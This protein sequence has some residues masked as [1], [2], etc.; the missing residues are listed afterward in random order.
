MKHK[1]RSSGTEPG[2]KPAKVVE[3]RSTQQNYIAAMSERAK[4]FLGSVKWTCLVLRRPEVPSRL[5]DNYPCGTGMRA[6]GL[7]Q[8]LLLSAPADVGGH[9][10]VS[11]HLRVGEA[12][13]WRA[14]PGAPTTSVFGASAAATPATVCVQGLP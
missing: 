11:G 13:T 3:M 6:G 8:R 4:K 2:H 14:S 9:T 12:C 1:R 5:E 7:S 10:Y